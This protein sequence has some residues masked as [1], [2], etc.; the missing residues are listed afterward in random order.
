MAEATEQS[1]RDV[2]GRLVARASKDQAFLATLKADPCAAVADEL[3]Q[4]D[5]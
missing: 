2:E 1:R 4:V 5:G 3:V